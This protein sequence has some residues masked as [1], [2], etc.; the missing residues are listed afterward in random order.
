M[1][2]YSPEIR[3]CSAEINKSRIKIEELKKLLTKPI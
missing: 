1:G 2:N 3:D